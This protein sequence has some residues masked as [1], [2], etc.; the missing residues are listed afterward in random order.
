MNFR[1]FN[2]L[3]KLFFLLL[4]LLVIDC[5]SS[6]K[7]ENVYNYF[8]DYCSK[9][10]ES[11]YF[12]KIKKGEIS[13]ISI[14]NFINELQD[15]YSEEKIW[16]E[17]RINEFLNYINNLEESDKLDSNFLYYIKGLLLLKLKKYENAYNIFKNINGNPYLILSQRNVDYLS[18]L[19]NKQKKAN[20]DQENSK[21]EEEK[22]INEMIKKIDVKYI[23]FINTYYEILKG[24]YEIIFSKYTDKKEDNSLYSFERTNKL[25][26]FLHT[27][28][29]EEINKSI[30]DQL[31]KNKKLRIKNVDI[32]NLTE[33][34]I[35]SYFTSL[36]N[37]E[38]EILNYFLN[39]NLIN[40]SN[41][42]KIFYFLALI[43]LLQGEYNLFFDYLALAYV[44]G[45]NYYYSILS[46]GIINSLYSDEKFINLEKI[47]FDESKDIINKFEHFFYKDLEDFFNKNKIEHLIKNILKEKYNFNNEEISKFIDLLKILVNHG[48]SDR[49]INIINYLSS[50]SDDKIKLYEINRN[51]GF[52]IGNLNYS[53]YYQNLIFNEK[54]KNFYINFRDNSLFFLKI[55]NK[56]Y[57]MSDKNLLI[58]EKKDIHTKDEIFSTKKDLNLFLNNSFYFDEEI[59]NIFLNFIASSNLYEY[60]F[61]FPYFFMDL[62]DKNNVEKY[63]DSFE[64]LSLLREESYF[65]K[66]AVS[67]AGAIGLMQLMPSTAYYLYYK[68]AYKYDKDFINK[69]S[70][71]ET[72]IILGIKY[73]NQVYLTLNSKGLS[74]AAYNGGP[75]RIKR[76]FQNRSFYTLLDTEFINISETQIYIK[77]IMRSYLFYKL[78]YDNNSIMDTFGYIIRYW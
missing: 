71:P 18:S 21:L 69:L 56:I 55:K 58:K 29:S 6:I 73:L 26:L 9:F 48:F 64:I 2:K 38:Y 34:K 11:Q 7:I 62:I 17:N 12:N 51:F 3:L 43:N 59:L 5:N 74:F 30:A 63:F 47:F 35:Y 22:Y 14:Y 75:N 46:Y 28:I 67:P 4:F 44:C 41:I 8:N 77:K 16:D 72:S 54:S 32:I 15:L 57:S 40:L 25:K 61:S 19:I 31:E 78:I 27:K 60:I 20:N 66:D 52:F 39:I 10:Y 76:L 33:E 49:F 23:E 24:F 42:S 65:K 68:K 70:E 36:E 45:G 37:L 50:L 13:K 53:V 1:N